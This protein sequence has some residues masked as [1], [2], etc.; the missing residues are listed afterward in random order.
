MADQ[1]A[2]TRKS[3]ALPSDV[4]VAAAGPELA[5]PERPVTALMMSLV[6]HV[7][8][9]T[10]IGLAWS[11]I[12]KGTGE[13]LD[14]PIGIALVHRLPDRDQYVDATQ[15]AQPEV[16]TESAEAESNAEA[17]AAAAPPAELTPPI[18]LTGVLKAMEATPAPVSGNGLA[19]ETDLSGDAFG[20]AR[21]EKTHRQRVMTRPRS[22]SVSPVAVRDSFTSLIAPIA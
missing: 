13:T 7:V 10:V 22:S 11:Q 1:P 20:T 9:L 3:A 17:A 19:G 6:F 4:P 16:E 14:R 18:D 21:E 15:L 5:V 2:G 12:P 8:L